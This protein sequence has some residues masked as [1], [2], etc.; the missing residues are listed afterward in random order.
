MTWQNASEGKDAVA[1]IRVES[2]DRTLPAFR[3]VARVLERRILAGELP[4]GESLPS[5]LSLADHFGVSR[6]TV[7]EAIRVLE[8]RGLIRREKGRN[9]LRITAPQAKEISAQMKT[10]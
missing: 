9:R 3:A 1:T 6:S 5:E 7:R 2:R 10:A 4:V 8:Q